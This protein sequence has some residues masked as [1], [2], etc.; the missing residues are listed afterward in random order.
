[1]YC[2]K[3]IFK[4]SPNEIHPGGKRSVVVGR[5]TGWL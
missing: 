1:M 5:G 2:L 4:T 3:L